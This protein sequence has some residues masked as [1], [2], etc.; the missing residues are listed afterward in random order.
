MGVARAFRRQIENY[1]G[2]GALCI[3]HRGERVVDLW[4]GSR[5]ARGDAW[6][7]N[8]MA[9]SFSTTKGV[10]STLV[11]MMVDRGLLDYDQ[12]VSEYW[13]EF[14]RAGKRNI[15]LRKTGGTW[16]PRLSLTCTDPLRARWSPTW[17]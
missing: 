3:Y 12:R 16:G 10:A 2:G 4:G 17:R 1:A 7:Q 13:P 15:T 5:N 8:T 14:G 11:H 9:P 6:Q